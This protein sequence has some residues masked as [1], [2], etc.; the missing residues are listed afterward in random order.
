M[1]PLLRR[2]VGWSC[3][4]VGKVGSLALLWLLV[5]GAE[6]GDVPLD[7]WALFALFGMTAGAVVVGIRVLMLADEDSRQDNRQDGRA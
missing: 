1:S 7:P 6:P 3:I 5:T 4:A 2:L